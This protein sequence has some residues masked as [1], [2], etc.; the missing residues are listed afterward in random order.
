[1]ALVGA[2]WLPPPEAGQYWLSYRSGGEEG[3]PGLDVL[4]DAV[5]GVVIESR[6]PG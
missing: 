3:S 4:L 6:Q 1:M 2:R 5:H